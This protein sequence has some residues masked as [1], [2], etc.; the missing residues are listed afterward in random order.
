MINTFSYSTM[1]QVPY[2]LEVNLSTPPQN[3]IVI[4][5]PALDLPGSSFGQGYHWNQGYQW[6]KKGVIGILFQGYNR[7]IVPGI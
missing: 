2:K 5:P 6:N 3:T 7:N 1:Q 4:M